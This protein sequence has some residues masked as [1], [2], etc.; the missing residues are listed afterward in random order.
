[1]SA[2]FACET[3]SKLQTDFISLLIPVLLASSALRN[4][5]F[6]LVLIQVAR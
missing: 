4:F 6:K 5:A 1:M 2:L 3:E